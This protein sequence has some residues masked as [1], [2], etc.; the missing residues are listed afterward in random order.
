MLKIKLNLIFLNTCFRVR[1]NFFLHNP[2]LYNNNN[3]KYHQKKNKN[4]SWQQ[5]KRNLYLPPP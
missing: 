1:L 2:R 4:Y 3:G 5:R